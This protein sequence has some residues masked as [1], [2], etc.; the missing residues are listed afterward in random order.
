MHLFHLDVTT[1]F[2]EYAFRVVANPAAWIRPSGS[3]GR[4]ASPFF[5]C[6]LGVALA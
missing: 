3:R 1:N 4:V 6:S 5:H 2:G